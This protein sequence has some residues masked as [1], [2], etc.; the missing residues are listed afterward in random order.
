MSQ[1]GD[2]TF[3]CNVDFLRKLLILF[4]LF[5]ISK[6]SVRYFSLNSPLKTSTQEVLHNKAVPKNYCKIHR[7]I[8][9]PRFTFQ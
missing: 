3:P 1:M 7:E 8:S 5:N 2:G 4:Y 9:M 6:M